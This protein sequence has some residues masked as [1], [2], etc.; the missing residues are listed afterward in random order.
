MKKFLF[1]TSAFICLFINV[2][3]QKR[4]LD[5]VVAVVGNNIILLSDLTQ[6]YA[7]YLSSGNPP[8]DRVKCVYLQQMLIQKLLKQ[9]AE[10]DKNGYTNQNLF[11]VQNGFK[12][13]SKN[14][15]ALL[16]FKGDQ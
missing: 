6:Q 14:L 16:K 8:E 10:I 1:I 7:I 9:Q 4:N 13:L 15:K 12:K 5:K 3:A 2:Q 11:L